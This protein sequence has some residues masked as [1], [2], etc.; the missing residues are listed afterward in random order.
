MKF[1][2]RFFILI[3]IMFTLNACED[4]RLLVDLP[5]ERLDIEV[6]NVDSIIINTPDNEFN[7]R[8]EYLKE[9]LGDPYIYEASMNT[10]QPDDSDLAFVLKRFY[11]SES[12]KSIET[13]K[14]L[15][16]EQISN[17]VTDLKQAFRYLIYHFPKAP[18]PDRLAFMNNL[19]SGIQCTDSSVFVGLER[20]ID[21]DSDIVKSIPND[22]LYQWQKDAMNIRFLARDII[23]QWIQ[24]HLFNDNDEHLAYH[25][26]QAG[27][28]LYLLRATF[29]KADNA[30]LMRFSQEEIDWA[31]TNEVLFWEYLVREEFLF[32]NNVR[33]KSNF[34]N[35]GPYTVGLP[36]KGPARMGQ[37]LGMK[38]VNQFMKANKALSLQQLLH[39]EYNTILQEYEIGN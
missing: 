34:L 24:V 14:S 38:M 33:D 4:N 35:E 39:I 22:Q 17:Q 31:N 32:K 9:Q 19:F 28:V 20:Y 37:F 21:G 11:E 29:P 13:Q 2:S 25:I 3:L 36:E 16:D 26:V 8:H 12:I 10:R 15:L 27:K 5:E 1:G 6:I 18:I 30:F 23:Q 7:D